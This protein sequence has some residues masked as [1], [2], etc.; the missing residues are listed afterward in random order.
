MERFMVNVIPQGKLYN[1][2]GSFNVRDLGGLPTHS[3][4]TTKTGRFIRAGSISAL[5]PAGRQ[6]LLNLGVTTVIDLRSTIEAGHMPDA[7]MDDGAFSWRHIPMMDYMNSNIA[8][9]IYTYPETMEQMYIDILG[10]LPEAF[11]RLFELLGDAGHECVL[12]HC[13][14]GKDRTG[15]VAIMLLSLSGVPEDVIVH[16]YARS[17]EFLP[18]TMIAR[19]LPG[20]PA[21]LHSS[22]PELCRAVLR[23]LESAYGGVR[24]YLS[25]AGITPEQLDCAVKK[26]VE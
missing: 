17:A 12:F 21:Y 9:D 15:A 11:A 18:T 4:K 14:A 20:V 10:R 3:G 25:Q 26:L 19:D 1:I 24:G 22:P 8:A 13:A 23:H 16:D 5:T 7:I 2:E 6:A